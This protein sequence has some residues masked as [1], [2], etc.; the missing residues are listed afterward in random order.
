MDGTAAIKNNLE[1]LKRILAGLASMAGLGADALT[2][3]LWGGRREASGGGRGAEN[4]PTRRSDDRRPPH[5]GEVTAL[6]PSPAMANRPAR[7]R[8]SASRLKCI[9]AV[10][11]IA[12][13]F[14]GGG[15]IARAGRGV[16]KRYHSFS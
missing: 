6:A 15:I 12:A 13:S 9:A 16:E 1:A 3:P 5:K 7:I 11:S 10:P 4:T 2:S 14:Q 8:F